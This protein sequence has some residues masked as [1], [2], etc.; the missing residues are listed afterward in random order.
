MIDLIAYKKRMH[1][2]GEDKDKYSLRINPKGRL[3]FDKM[4]ALIAERTT[5]TDYEVKF[6]LAEVMQ[7]IIENIEIGRGTE[8]GPLGS[9]ELSVKAD[10]VDTEEELNKK[11][12]EKTKILYKPS[13]DIKKALKEVK[14][15][16]EK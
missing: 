3:D 9:I 10:A 16:I 12:I 2:N 4:C 1:I 7:V 8:L 11:L 5:L 15:K 14:Y 6:A 13:K